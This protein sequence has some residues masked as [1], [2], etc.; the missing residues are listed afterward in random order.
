MRYN[1]KIFPITRQRVYQIVKKLG[2]ITGIE[3][4]GKKP[5]HPHIFRHSF[6][7]NLVKNGLDVRKLQ[8]LLGHSRLSASA[9]YLQFSQKDVSEELQEIWSKTIKSEK[10]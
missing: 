5:I 4:V 9:F 3:R 10:T 1:D 7:V 8:M 6:A 2:K